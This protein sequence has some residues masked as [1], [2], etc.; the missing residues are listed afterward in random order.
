MH[1]IYHCVLLS[2]DV[3]ATFAAWIGRGE[4]Q[5]IRHPV[6]RVT[7]K[8]ETTMMVS[9]IKIRSRFSDVLPEGPLAGVWGVKPRQRAFFSRQKTPTLSPAEGY[10]YIH[11]IT[12]SSVRIIFLFPRSCSDINMGVKDIGGIDEIIS[13]ATWSQMFSHSGTMMGNNV[14][15]DGFWFSTRITINFSLLSGKWSPRN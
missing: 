6:P 1:A 8:T 4:D 7:T 14:I 10:I 13:Q 11:K 12:R 9:F 15:P 3:A 5:M 2:L